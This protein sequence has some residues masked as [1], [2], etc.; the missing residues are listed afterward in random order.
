MD[1]LPSFRS[2]LTHALFISCYMWVR[3]QTFLKLF[4]HS[5]IIAN[6]SHAAV[7]FFLVLFIAAIPSQCLCKLS[8]KAWFPGAVC[9]CG[10]QCN[11]KSSANSLHPFSLLWCKFC[12]KP[13][14]GLP[15]LIISWATWYLS[16]LYQ[17]PV[18][19]LPSLL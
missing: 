6:T 13:I 19:L 14:N 12:V 1:S 11:C 3:P 7:S 18:V 8:S 10:M 9:P 5:L 2:C 17:S 4:P 15:V 16:N